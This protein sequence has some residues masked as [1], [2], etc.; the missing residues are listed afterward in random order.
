MINPGVVYGPPINPASASA[1]SVTMVKEIWQGK[2]YPAVPK[3]GEW[4][5]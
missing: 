2:A 5:C 1:E 4:L 3:M